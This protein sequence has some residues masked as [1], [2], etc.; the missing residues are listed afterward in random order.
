MFNER[1]KLFRKRKGI[2]QEEL[3]NRLHVARQTISKWESGTSV[4]DATMLVK[5]SEQLDVSVSELLGAHIEDKEDTDTISEKLA[6]IN[7]TLA[8]RNRRTQKI[9]KIV[10][11]FVV[12]VIVL[13]SVLIALNV[14]K[15]GSTT[16]EPSVTSSSYILT[17]D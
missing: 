15:P 9:I 14:V 4:P 6:S 5:I 17:D 3:A 16:S 10:I 12:A 1:L 2:S 8:V 11:G 13:V 7:E